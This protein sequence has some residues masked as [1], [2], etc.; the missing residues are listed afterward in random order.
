MMVVGKKRKG[1]SIIYVQLLFVVF[2]NVFWW[3]SYYEF[4]PPFFAISHISISTASATLAAVFADVSKK[5]HLNS[6]ASAFFCCF[7]SVIMSTK[8]SDT[9]IRLRKLC[10]LTSAA[11]LETSRWFSKSHLLP[12]KTIGTLS[13]SNVQRIRSRSSFTFKK[14][15][16]DVMLYTHKNPS[17]DRINYKHKGECL[18][19]FPLVKEGVPCPEVPMNTLL[20]LLYQWFLFQCLSR[21]FCILFCRHPLKWLFRERV[22]PSTV[23]KERKKTNLL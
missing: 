11:S 6:F 7:Q 3:I 10:W 13:W 15:C 19:F 21:R 17:P 8:T 23:K 9:K 1:N 20:V 12:I 16:I 4:A 2:A 5:G 18:F 14:V 22:L